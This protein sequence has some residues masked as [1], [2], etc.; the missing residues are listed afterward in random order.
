VKFVFFCAYVHR[1]RVVPIRGRVRPKP[2]G[3]ENL[4]QGLPLVSRYKR[5][6]L[7]GLCSAPIFADLAAPSGLIREGKLPRV[8]PELCFL[9]HI[10]PQIGNVHPSFGRCDAKHLSGERKF[11]TC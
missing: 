10:G 1:A 9:G 4:A 7:K 2:K 8:N 5:F 11:L 3:Q 6:A